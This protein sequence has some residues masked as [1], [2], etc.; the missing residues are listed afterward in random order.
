M[1]TLGDQSEGVVDVHDVAVVTGGGGGG[2]AGSPQAGGR[3]RVVW[4]DSKNEKL[5]QKMVSN[6][7]HYSV[8]YNSASFATSPVAGGHDDDDLATDSAA[9]GGAAGE[10]GNPKIENCCVIS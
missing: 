1:A 7:L 5:T 4:A 10:P 2:A 8:N 6:R 3:K 9:A